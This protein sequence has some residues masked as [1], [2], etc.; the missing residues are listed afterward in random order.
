MMARRRPRLLASGLAALALTVGLA[1]CGAEDD[2]ELTG[3]DTPA[4]STPTTAE[5]EPEPTEPSETASPTPTPSPTASP[6]Q[7]PAATEVTD[8]PTA[9]RGFTGQLLTADELPGF[10]DEFTWQETSTTKR[11]G[12][13]PFATCAKFAMASIG[14]MKVAVR[15]FTPAD[16]SS[17]ST[18]SN[19]VARFGDEMTAK[20]AYEVLKSW[21]GQCAEE[22]QRYDRTDIGRLQSVPLENEDAVG[23][24]YLLTYGPAPERETAYFDAQGLTRVGDSISLV[25]MRLVGQDYNYRAGQEPMVGAVQE[26]ADNLG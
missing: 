6:T 26:A 5:P 10:N 19:L 24:W 9:R 13:Q 25:Q 21:R 12:R 2:P 1:G 20:R 17:G 18:A 7:T 14:A 22:L 3:S 23:D 4:S 15:E 11:E 8:E 16:G